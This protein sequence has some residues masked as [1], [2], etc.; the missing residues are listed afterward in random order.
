MPSRPPQAR[1]VN[2][3]RYDVPVSKIVSGARRRRHRRRV[4]L[5]AVPSVALLAAAGYALRSEPTSELFT[6]GCYASLDQ[7]ADTT[8]IGWD[9]GKT[10]AESCLNEPTAF[11]EAVPD[12]VVTCVVNGGGTGV[13]PNPQDLNANEACASIGAATPEEQGSHYGGLTADQVRE[14]D[15]ELARRTQN[16]SDPDAKEICYPNE[17]LKRELESFLAERGFT[18][19]SVNDITTDQAARADNGQRCRDLVMD[20]LE[21]TFIITDGDRTTTEPNERAATQLSNRSA[22]RRPQ[23]LSGSQPRLIGRTV[24]PY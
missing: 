9:K 12:R 20:E 15:E 10:A 13:F 3:V 11:G 16:L 23:G 22:T 24:L 14:M 1:R 5:G 2:Q 18:K 6:V 19:W 4:V 7:Q 21:A 17:N 8:I